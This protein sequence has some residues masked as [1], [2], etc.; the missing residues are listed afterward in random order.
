MIECSRV[1]HRGHSKAAHLDREVAAGGPPLADGQQHRH[2]GR[3]V[4]EGREEPHLVRL[5]VRVRVRVR[6]RA[7]ARARARVRVRVRVRVRAGSR[8][9]RCVPSSEV[10]GARGLARLRLR[11]S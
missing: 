4:E 6:V 11:V 7:R 3:V 10:R 1:C 5:R 8:L 9:E 2:D